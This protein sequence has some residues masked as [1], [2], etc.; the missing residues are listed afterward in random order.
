MTS[1]NDFFKKIGLDFREIFNKNK[2]LS[3]LEKT[4]L[5]RLGGEEKEVVIESQKKPSKFIKFANNIFYETS[6]KLVKQGNFSRIKLDVIRS[7]LQLTLASYVSIILFSTVLA[8][9]FSFFLF[10][11]LLFFDFSFQFPFISFISGSILDRF[12]SVFWILFVIP[13][14]VFVFAYFYPSMEKKSTEGK[15]NQE[16]PFATINMAAIAG[17]MVN[18]KKIFEVIVETGE[19]PNLKKEFTKLLNEVNIYGY[20]LTTALRNVSF[21]C[22]SKKLS[23]LFSGLSTTITSG[24]NLREFFDERS[25]S[26]LFEHRLEKEKASK[27]AETFMDIYISIVIAAPMIFMLLLIVMNISGM[28]S[29]LSNLELTMIIVLIVGFVNIFFLIFLH[30]KQPEPA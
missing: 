20:D 12:I 1:L 16:L 19:Y 4:S 26:L 21:N 23:E 14:S 3:E 25:N 27:F 6:Y 18:P 22:P 11:M 30:L 13:L 9:I 29:A 8:A 24:G 17:S 2:G 7:N 15:I 10:L 28:G 5:K